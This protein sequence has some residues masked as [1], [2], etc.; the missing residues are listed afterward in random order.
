MRGCMP[1]KYFYKNPK[2]PIEKLKHCT[3]G[4]K[5]V[6]TRRGRDYGITCP[7]M[8]GNCDINPVPL[9]VFTELAGAIEDWNERIEG[10]KK[11]SARLF[12]GI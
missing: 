3:C 9:P 12:N 11:M 1:S 6:I 5:A 7:N 8:S 2:P 4:K 10:A